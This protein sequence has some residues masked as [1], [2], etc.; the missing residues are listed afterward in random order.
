[1]AQN[2]SGTLVKAASSAS[3]KPSPISM[4]LLSKQMCEKRDI[5]MPALTAREN[6]K[7]LR[8]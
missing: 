1:M 4:S 7:G 3:K 5:P 8:E 6:D 2:R